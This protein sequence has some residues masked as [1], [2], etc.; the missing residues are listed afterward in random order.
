[1]L[2]KQNE[3][4]APDERM[5]SERAFIRSQLIG[6]KRI[7]DHLKSRKIGSVTLQIYTKLSGEEKHTEL[8]RSVMTAADLPKCENVTELA[9]PVATSMIGSAAEGT[10]YDPR[11]PKI[12]ECWKVELNQYPNLEYKKK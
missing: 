10:V 9:D 11:G 8:F 4:T 2:Q 3:D 7:L 12:G 6:C 5:Q 1:M